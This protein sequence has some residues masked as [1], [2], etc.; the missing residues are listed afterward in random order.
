MTGE[1]QELL[2]ALVKTYRPI[3]ELI[4]AHW[5]EGDV[6]ANGIRHHYYR[7]GGDKP[8]LLLPHGFNF[9]H[10][11]GKP[12]PWEPLSNHISRLCT[13]RILAT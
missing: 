5:R 3:E 7:T 9:L 13:L 12:P 11:W 10:G 4:P 2:Q 1:Q 8:P 6:L